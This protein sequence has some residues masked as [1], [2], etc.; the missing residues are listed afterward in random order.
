MSNQPLRRKVVVSN[1]QG[2]HMRPARLLVEQ[3]GLFEAKIT[4]WKDEE[5]ADCASFLS[6]MTLGAECGTE[7]CLTAEGSDAEEAAE[8]ITRLFDNGFYEPEEAESE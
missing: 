2:L 1:P 6:L 8:A 5:P 4:L 7:L 3:A